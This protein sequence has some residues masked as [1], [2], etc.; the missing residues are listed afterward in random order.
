MYKFNKVIDEAISE[1]VY[2]VEHE[3]NINE[4]MHEEYGCL[5]EDDVSAA[6]IEYIA[7]YYAVMEDI[8]ERN[9]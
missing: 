5:V 3:E 6:V 8:V 2:M 7:R 1:L 4:F 9:S